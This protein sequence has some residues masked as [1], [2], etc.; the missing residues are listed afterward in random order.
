M[1]LS[2]RLVTGNLRQ[3]VQGARGGQ[4][5]LRAGPVQESAFTKH[6]DAP[7]HHLV[8]RLR[9]SSRT[10]LRLRFSLDFQGPILR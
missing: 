6:H 5:L 1:R 3:S 4:N 2:I 7:D 10:R 8:S 9:R